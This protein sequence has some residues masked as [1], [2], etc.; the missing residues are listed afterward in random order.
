MN[1]IEIRPNNWQCEDCGVTFNVAKPE[2]LR[3]RCYMAN[4][5]PIHCEWEEKPD[6]NGWYQCKDKVCRNRSRTRDR[7]ELCWDDPRH[8][9]HGGV[10]PG[11]FRQVANLTRATVLHLFKGSQ[12]C[13][14]EEIQR[15]WDICNDNCQYFNGRIC[16]HKSCGCSI[17]VE[18]K[19]FHKLGW[20]SQKCP[21]GKW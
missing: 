1:F 15:R 19:Y 21:V 14:D 16:T 2:N 4:G 13:S 9:Y 18:H 6:A 11:R 5:E 12:T 3:C 20:A 8:I 7:N 17:A 10:G